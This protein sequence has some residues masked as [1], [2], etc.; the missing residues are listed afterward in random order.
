MVHCWVCWFCVLSWMSEERVVVGRAGG[1]E[2][3]DDWDDTSTV[4]KRERMTVM[5]ILDAQLTP[6]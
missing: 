2:L 1:R 5:G 3:R 4:S 6:D